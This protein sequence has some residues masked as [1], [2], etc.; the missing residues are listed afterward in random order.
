MRKTKD[1]FIFG[2][3]FIVISVIAYRFFLFFYVQKRHEEIPTKNSES[4]RVE[5]HSETTLYLNLVN[6]LNDPID[7]QE[8]KAKKKR[9]VTTTVTN[10]KEYYFSP[11]FSDSILYNYY[12]ITENIENGLMN[13]AVVFKYGDNKHRYQ[14]TTEILIELK[15]FNKD[16]NLEEANLVGLTKTELETKFG[17]DYLTYENK[18]IYTHKNKIVLIELNNLKVTSFR[19]I[20]LNREN[21]DQALIQQIVG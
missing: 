6:F 5:A 2:F 16:S 3:A 18:I 13:Q 14:D 21:V 19:Y 20:H 7:L 10:G 1:I 4:L 12:F 8:F 17:I 11:K 9:N 15:V